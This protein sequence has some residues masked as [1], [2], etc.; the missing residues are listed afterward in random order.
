MRTKVK[1]NVKGIELTKYLK[2]EQSTRDFA[3][4]IAHEIEWNSFLTKLGLIKYEY[5]TI[6]EPLDLT[7]LK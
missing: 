5:I 7:S 1:V 4:C 2:T 3:Y 6:D